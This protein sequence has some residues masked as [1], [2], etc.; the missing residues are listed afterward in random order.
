[1]ITAQPTKMFKSYQKHLAA[2]IKAIQERSGKPQKGDDILLS[3]IGDG[4]HAAI[5]LRFVAPSLPNDPDSKLNLLIENAFRIYQENKDNIYEI[6][7]GV[8]YETTGAGQMIFSDL[9]TLAV[10]AR[11]GFSAYRWIK[12]QMIARGVPAGEIAFMQDH[13][14]PSEKQRLF[15]AFNAGLIRFLI[16]SSQTMGTGV[17][18]QKRLKALHHL[19]VPWLP[20]DIEQREGRIIRQGNQNEEVEVYCYATL[21][22][23][24]APMWGQNQRKQRFIEAALSGDR[25]IRRLEDAGS[26]SNQF[27]MAKAIAS[28][29]QRLMQKAGLEAE[30]A[31]LIR[32]QDAHIDNQMAVRRT[33]QGAK[34]SIEHNRQRVADITADLAQRMETRTDLFAF[35][36]SDRRFNERKA[37]GA[38]I[39]TT[40]MEA[41]W[42]DTSKIAGEFA[43]FKFAIKLHR[44]RKLLIEGSEFVIQRCNKRDLLEIPENLTPLGIIA[45]LEA[46]FGRFDAELEE[47]EMR[48]AEGTRRVA[49]YEPRLGQPFDLQGELDAK[50]AE[51]QQIDAALADTK[52][53]SDPEQDEFFHIFG[54][55]GRAGALDDED[56]GVVG[57]AYG[58]SAE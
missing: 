1:V 32:L 49:D 36:L 46:Y 12:E 50:Q 48:V 28:G 35:T 6:A 26:Q 31:R 14:K 9:G 45:R 41:G 7:P 22:S 53:S 44:D 27:A 54:P 58:D 4:R 11:R 39:L 51:L 19:D 18:A 21:T 20:S 55:I 15:T 56:D 5:D 42:D 43:G 10:E 24:D 38:A 40:I 23:M 2:R 25:S 34:A 8:P 16:G 57:A 30:I 13:K 47:A 17:N 29:D 3:V 52:E 37:A 33:I